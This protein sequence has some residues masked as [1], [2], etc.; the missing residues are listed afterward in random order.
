MKDSE[1]SDPLHIELKFLQ[2]LHDQL[3]KAQNN[4]EKLSLLNAHPHVQTYLNQNSWLKAILAKKSTEEKVAVT[5]LLAIGQGPQIFQSV[6]SAADCL[7][8]FDG[9]ISTLLDIEHAYDIVGGIVGYHYTVLKLIAAKQNPT[10]PQNGAVRYLH[11]PG[12]N[13]AHDI[14]EVRKAIRWGITSAGE[15]AEIYPVGGAGDRLDLHDEQTKEALPAA[16]LAFCG[17]SL[18]DTLIRD[19]QAKE[20]LHY[21]L[22]G[23]QLVTPIAMMTSYEKSNHQ[24]INRICQNNNWFGRPKSSFRLFVQPLVPVI[25]IK[26][27]WVMQ[28]PMKPMLKP[29]GHGVIWKLAKDEGIFDWLLA[30]GYRQGLVRQINNPVAGTDHGLL[31]FAGLGNH[32]KKTFGFASCQR[33]LNTAEGMDILVETAKDQGF[34]YC[35]TNVEYTEFE[36]CGIQ[37]VPASPKVPY[38]LFPANTN[39]LFIDLQAIKSIVDS[40]PIPGMLINMKNKVST[41]DKEGNKEEV[42]AGRLESTMQNIADQI[43][44]HFPKKLETVNPEALSTYVT[45]NERRKTISVAKKSY[46]SHGPIHETP[47]GAFYDLLQNHRDLLARYCHMQLPEPVSEHE[48]LRNGPEVLCLFHPALGPLY[49]V[50]GQKIHGGKLEPGAELQLEIAEL[51][52]RDLSLTGSLL[53]RADSVTGHCNR[54][55]LVQYSEKTGKCVVNRVT[56]KNR[57]IDHVRSK[58][59]WKNQFIRHEACEILL[60]GNAE[61]F[62][63]DVTFSGP[64][65]FVVPDGHRLVISPSGQQDLQKIATPSWYWSYSFDAEDHIILNKKAFSMS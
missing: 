55:G 17:R 24:H 41:T 30:L 32:Q 37:D 36:Q 51:D 47:E 25:S 44:D 57:G 15:I 29:G 62:A 42:Q 31:A 22:L 46:D 50:I 45:Y 16:D 28:A 7:S 59:Y 18:L 21:K 13:L 58:P 56:V 26:G 63:E 43:V 49:R 33:L 9:L 40:S 6:H 23:K 14:P 2:S 5:S 8:H 48:Y 39:I 38:S 65:K 3:K 1:I 27:D 54:E 12:T 4:E 35:I 10:T 20:Y 60:E 61:F 52:M 19:L 53:I 11:P 64:Q 34:D